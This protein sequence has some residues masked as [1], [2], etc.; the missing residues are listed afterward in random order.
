MEELNLE[1]IKEIEINI[2]K[3]VD[4]ICKR[5]KLNYFLDSGTLLGAVR[6]QGFIPWDDDIDIV[7]P[8]NDYNRLYSILCEDSNYRMITYK[9]DNNYF[10]PHAKV[11]D[12]NT[13]LVEATKS[14]VKTNYG[15][16]I[17][18]FPLDNLPNNKLARL[19]QQ[20]LVRYYRIL[21]SSVSF[22]SESTEI[23]HMIYKILSH[24]KTSRDF[25]LMIDRRAEKY[26][27]RSTNFLANL[28]GTSRPYRKEESKWFREKKILRFEDFGY[29]VPIGYDA[30]LRNL[31]GDYM[32][33]PPVNQQI[34]NHTFKAY[35]K[36]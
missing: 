16:F 19:F 23:K 8:R 36:N 3:Y 6:H 27:N 20:N 15:V 2:L 12:L 10:L 31:Y 28:T 30:Y 4:G 9:N 33:L 21:W 25:A 5:E 34:T 17:D 24:G 35:W 13:I 11:C 32:K 14:S 7:M 1:E 29:P 18:V 26:T 22:C